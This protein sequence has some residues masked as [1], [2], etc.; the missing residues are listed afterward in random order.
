[1]RTELSDSSP[2]GSRRN[3]VRNE[4]SVTFF[5]LLR[6]WEGDV[7]LGSL[8]NRTLYDLLQSILSLGYL[9]IAHDIDAQCPGRPIAQGLK[10]QRRYNSQRMPANGR[11][12]RILRCSK[13]SVIES[14]A[15]EER[16]HRVQPKAVIGNRVGGEMPASGADCREIRSVRKGDSA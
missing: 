11:S 15:D 1:M 6:R 2:Q 8:A 10:A 14:A 5:M 13:S 3:L 9:R 12:R 7:L 4:S 16:S